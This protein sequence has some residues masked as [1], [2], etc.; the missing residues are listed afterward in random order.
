MA[1]RECK[2]EYPR[3]TMLNFVDSFTFMQGLQILPY[4]PFD[5]SCG[6]LR[7]TY[8]SP[9]PKKIMPVK[10]VNELEERVSISYASHEEP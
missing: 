5:R 10:F 1:A 7:G 4:D 3:N 8:R 2:S 6:I 9:A